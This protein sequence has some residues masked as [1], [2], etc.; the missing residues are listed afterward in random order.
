MPVSAY[1][2]STCFSLSKE[3]KKLKTEVKEETWRLFV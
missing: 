1:P 2:K 3:K